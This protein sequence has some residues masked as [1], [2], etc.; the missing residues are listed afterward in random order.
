MSPRSE[1]PFG[2][3]AD[4]VC[5]GCHL[6]ERRGVCPA[7]RDAYGLQNSPEAQ[8]RAAAFRAA[9]AVEARSN[10]SLAA[11]IK[12]E[13]RA[14]PAATRLGLARPPYADP[15]VPK[16]KSK[17]LIDVVSPRSAK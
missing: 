7:A 1:F 14:L 11:L 17:E 8:R 16:A 15:F 2:D 9:L 10:P 13:P 5:G 12:A 3:N 6:Y 4:D